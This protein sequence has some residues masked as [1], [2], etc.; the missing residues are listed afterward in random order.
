MYNYHIYNHFER[1]MPKPYGGPRG[2]VLSYERG[3][4]VQGSGTTIKMT[5][6]TV[7]YV[8]FIKSQLA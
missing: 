1:S 6:H 5:C 2:R 4:S 8:T 3:A 7:D